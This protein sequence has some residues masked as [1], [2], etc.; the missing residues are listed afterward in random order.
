MK[1]I[2]LCIA[3]IIG[4]F[5]FSCKKDTSTAPANIVG[6][7]RWILTYYNNALSDSNP[8]NPT[9]TGINELMVFKSDNTWYQKKT[10]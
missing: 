8:K 3:L 1:Q 4:I 2:L 6:Q 10:T 9:N 5:T 7:W